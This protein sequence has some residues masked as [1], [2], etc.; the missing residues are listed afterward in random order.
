M[1]SPAATPVPRLSLRCLAL[2]LHTSPSLCVTEAWTTDALLEALHHTAADEELSPVKLWWLSPSPMPGSRATD[3]SREDAASTPAPASRVLKRTQMPSPSTP[4]TK[5][6]R[7]GNVNK[8]FKSPLAKPAKQ[9][10]GMTATPR[11]SPLRHTKQQYSA[12][13]PTM[14]TVDDAERRR[15]LARIPR[16]TAA[17]IASTM[18]ANKP[19]GS[20]SN[21]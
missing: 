3:E 18:D 20:R 8:P 14:P 21:E 11:A 13:S 10:S 12:R 16:G 1:A 17:T 6:H 9:E 15:L 7:L 2:L 5:R 4:A 19:N